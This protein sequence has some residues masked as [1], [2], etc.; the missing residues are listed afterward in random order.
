MEDEAGKKAIDDLFDSERNGLSRLNKKR[1]NE[2][3]KEMQE[4]SKKEIEEK[5]EK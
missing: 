4:T 3:I 5:E 2:L 1:I